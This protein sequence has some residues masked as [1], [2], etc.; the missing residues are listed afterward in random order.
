[1]NPAD[2][3]VN[4]ALKLVPIELTASTI[5]IEMPAAMIAYSIAVAPLS[6]RKNGTSIGI[7]SSPELVDALP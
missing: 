7:I 1:L 6:S 5:T 3:A 4:T 2:T